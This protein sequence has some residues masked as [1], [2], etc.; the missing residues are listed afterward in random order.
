MDSSQSGRS[1]SLVPRCSPRLRKLGPVPERRPGM[2]K[3]DVSV[4]E[5]VGGWSQRETEIQAVMPQVDTPEPVTQLRVVPSSQ[6]PCVQVCGVE[7]LHGV[8]PARAWCSV[9]EAACFARC[10]STHPLSILCSKRPTRAASQTEQPA[11]E[12]GG[13]AHPYS[14]SP[15]HTQHG[16]LV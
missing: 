1:P 8:P 3:A 5:S 15:S 2:S 14:W 13:R 12:P 9:G 6:L 10:V 11:L 16:G 7:G 4:T